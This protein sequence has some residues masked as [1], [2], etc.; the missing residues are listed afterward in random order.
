MP[1]VDGGGVG[2]DSGRAADPDLAGAG[3]RAS[4]PAEPADHGPAE[5]MHPGPAEPA[6]HGR[7][8][9]AD[10]EP[11]DP[12]LRRGLIIGAIGLLVLAGIGI[13]AQTP[14][15][16]TGV[17]TDRVGPEQ[18][19]E[20]SEYLTRAR[21]TLDRSDDAP[22][23]ALVSFTDHVQAERVPALAGEVRVARVLQ[24]VP[25]E[26][27]Q[28]PI[29]AIPVPDSASA[30]TG[31]AA[32]AADILRDRLD[33]QPLEQRAA[34]VH[35]VAVLRLRAGCACTAGL[36]VRAAPAELRELAAR[37]G[38]RA[39]EALPADTVADRFA[40]T[41]LLPGTEGTVRPEPDDGPV[42]PR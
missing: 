23:W 32:A 19:E 39:V 14:P 5:P 11:L 33:R 42:P 16:S 4:A 31:A 26:R 3:H 2:P 10:V 21:A 34:Q 36:V 12:R 7:A 27:V 8:E 28:T 29:V 18:G 24:H 13:G 1:E 40:V 20:V 38:I 15:R 6:D 41:P 22:R 9:P 37:T 17:S 25:L 30:V 35:E